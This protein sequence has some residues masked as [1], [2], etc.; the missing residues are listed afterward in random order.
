MNDKRKLGKRKYM[1]VVQSEKGV[2]CQGSEGPIYQLHQYFALRFKHLKGSNR[3]TGWYHNANWGHDSQV[4]VRWL[5]TERNGFFGS[6][7]S[8]R[9][10]EA[11]LKIAVKVGKALRGLNY[12]AGPEDLMEALGAALVEYISDN[13]EGCWDDYRP[14]QVPGEAAM[15]TIARYAQ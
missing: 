11:G 2:S 5:W 13:K 15:L 6:E 12:K 9:P 4:E 7:I 10:T 3:P 14:L 1:T 8:F